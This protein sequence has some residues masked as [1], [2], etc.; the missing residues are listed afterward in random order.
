M[1]RRQCEDADAEVST[2]SDGGTMIV[3]DKACRPLISVTEASWSE[4]PPLCRHA[5]AHARHL[6]KVTVCRW[7]KDGVEVNKRPW[8][9]APQPLDPSGVPYVN[10]ETKNFYARMISPSK[11]TRKASLD[12]SAVDI[13]FATNYSLKMP[14]RKASMDMRPADMTAYKDSLKKPMRKASMDMC[15]VP[16]LYVHQQ[17]SHQEACGRY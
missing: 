1:L 4:L 8:E 3:V 14:M 17:S 13:S 12:M 10:Q 6:K 15:V 5:P 7:G 9:R 16:D 11:P 2:S